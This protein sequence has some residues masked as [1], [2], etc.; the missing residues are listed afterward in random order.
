MVSKSLISAN[1][2]RGRH[3]ECRPTSPQT[4]FFRPISIAWRILRSQRYQ[5]V[6]TGPQRRSSE[7]GSILLRLNFAHQKAFLIDLNVTLSSKYRRT[8]FQCV[9]WRRRSVFRSGFGVVRHIPNL[10]AL[11]QPFSRLFRLLQST[12]NFFTR[13]ISLNTCPFLYQ[14][15]RD[16]V[17]PGSRQHVG[18]PFRFFFF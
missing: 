6:R 18:R 3:T 14:A 12:L 15:C 4:Y 10:V 8:D 11:A 13:L 17:R 9:S 16:L 2:V 5:W 7:K 1:P